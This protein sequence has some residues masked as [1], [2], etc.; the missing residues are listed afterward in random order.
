M[1]KFKLTRNDR[2]T[3][4]ELD[5]LWSAV[6]RARDGNVCRYHKELFNRECTEVLQVHHILKK[7]TARLRFDLDSG[8]TICKGVHFAIA[9]SQKPV[10][11]NQFRE[12]AIGRLPK[13][14]REKLEMYQYA[15]GGVDRFAL[16]IYLQQKLKEYT[17]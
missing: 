3:D 13:K 6:C 11:E 10:Q 15:V 12:W 2:P 9:H 4:K 7:C 16:K 8:L 1:K 17:K 14:S 5:K